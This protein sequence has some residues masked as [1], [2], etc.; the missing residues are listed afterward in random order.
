M[1]IIYE[2]KRMKNAPYKNKYFSVVGDSIST[3]EDF[4]PDGYKVFY[5]GERQDIADIYSPEDTW[6]GKV[7]S[8][9]GGKL[10][11]NASWSGS[12]VAKLPDRDELFPSGCSDER[13]SCLHRDGITP[14]VIIVYLGTNDFMFGVSPAYEGNIQILKDQS[15]SYSYGKMLDKIKRN[16]PYA[17]I[18]C[19]TLCTAYMEKDPTFRFSEERWNSFMED[20]NAIIRNTAVEKGLHLVDLY[21]H[22]TAYDSIEGCHPTAKGMETLAELMI[23]EIEK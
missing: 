6:W 16:Y 19:C 2:V 22:G 11:V 23:K 15:F 21:A 14:D 3:L 18:F 4:N 8:H 20:F 7:I 13:T 10:L 17:E 1:Y 5:C 12:W 9:F